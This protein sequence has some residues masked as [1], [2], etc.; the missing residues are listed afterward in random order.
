MADFFKQDIPEEDLR[1]SLSLFRAGGDEL[2]IFQLL[3]RAEI[4]LPFSGAT[5][6]KDSETGTVIRFDPAFRK[7]QKEIADAFRR[8]AESICM[9][10]GALCIPIDTALSPVEAIL[11]MS[12]RRKGMF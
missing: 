8:K 2:I 9:E 12:R 10:Y 6:L 1:R 3:D 4:E 7:R 5:H 11:E